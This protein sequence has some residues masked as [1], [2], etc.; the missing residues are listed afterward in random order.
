MGL[1][2]LYFKMIK[3]EYYKDIPIGLL[4]LNWIVQ[5][6]FRLNSDVP[7]SINFTSRIS[8][9]K[10]IEIPVSSQLSFAV[11]NGCY[12]VGSKNGVLKIG[13]GVIFANNVCIQT[14]N[15]GLKNRKEFECKVVEIGDNCWLGNSCTIL[16]GVQLGKNVTVGANSVVTKSFPDNVVIGGCP[17]KI[18]KRLS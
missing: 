15:H 9:Y 2:S 18:L 3:R 11:S 4:V 17:A 5:R 14:R 10:F 7:F 16:P 6:I 1:G 8:N 12:I 13:E